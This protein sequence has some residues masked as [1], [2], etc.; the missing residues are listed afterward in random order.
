MVYAMDMQTMIPLGVHLGTPW[1]S[2]SI[3]LCLEAYCREANKEGWK[4]KFPEME[5]PLDSDDG[6]SGSG[7]SEGGDVVN[8]QRARIEAGLERKRTKSKACGERGGW[9]EKM[10]CIRQKP[11]HSLP[12]LVKLGSV[13]AD[14]CE[15]PH[16][17]S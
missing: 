17:R 4:L 3:F 12:R 13:G 15:M 9:T 5:E 8:L 7:W 6:S 10:P 2:R 14:V 16:A 1:T 11:L